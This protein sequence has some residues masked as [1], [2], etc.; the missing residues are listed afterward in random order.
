M[1]LGTGLQPIY[2]AYNTVIELALQYATL[3]LICINILF[4]CIQ[5]WFKDLWHEAVG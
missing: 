5:F 3:M 4:M 2:L 1:H